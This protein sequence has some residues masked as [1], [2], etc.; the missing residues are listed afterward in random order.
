MSTNLDFDN[1][2][3]DAL[4]TPDANGKGI[5][6]TQLTATLGEKRAHISA[7]LSRLRSAGR[8]QMLGI[9]KGATYA[10]A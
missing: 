7:A 10:K 4:P 9:K 8:A 5:G 1:K 2:I 6:L 3:L